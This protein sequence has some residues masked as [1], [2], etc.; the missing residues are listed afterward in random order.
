MG[1][2]NAFDDP[3]NGVRLDVRNSKIFVEALAMRAAAR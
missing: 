3:L 1:L 2:P